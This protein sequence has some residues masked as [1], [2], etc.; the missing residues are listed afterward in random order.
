M[1]FYC[2]L[3]AL[4]KAYN[5]VSMSQ[6]NLGIRDPGSGVGS[7]VHVFP[8]IFFLKVEQFQNY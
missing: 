2:S 4:N 6:R 3:Y 7:R 8:P 1:F 5:E